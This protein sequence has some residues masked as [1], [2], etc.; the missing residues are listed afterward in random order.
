MKKVI[1]PVGL[2]LFTNF[3]KQN[4]SSELRTDFDDFKGDVNHFYAADEY[5]I[6]KDNVKALKDAVL[7]FALR[8][9]HASAEI[10]SIK[11][12]IK[13]IQKTYPHE[14]FTICLLA[15]DT[16]HSA[17]AVD[18][19][20]SP[21]VFDA[22][23]KGISGLS[24]TI[25]IVVVEKLQV[26][27]RED[28]IRYGMINLI[29]IIR[30]LS[31]KT[32]EKMALWKNIVLNITG[33]YKATIP[34]LTIL[35]QIYNIPLYY[36]FD[37][38]ESDRI[39][40]E[41]IR[42]PRAPIAI[43]W[44]IFERYSTLLQEIE[45]GVADFGTF[46]QQHTREVEEIYSC[47]EEIDDETE[48]KTFGFLSPLGMIL[49]EEFNAYYLV[50]VS[51]HIFYSSDLKK[52]RT[53]VEDAIKKLFHELGEHIK[54][55]IQNESDKQKMELKTTE[56]LYQYLEKLPSTSNLNHT[57]I[58][59]VKDLDN[60]RRKAFVFKYSPGKHEVRLCYDVE[61]QNSVITAITVFD[62]VAGN[63]SHNDYRKQFEDFYGKYIEGSEY[64]YLQ[65]LPK[66]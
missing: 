7:E 64:H 10:S 16:F 35:S 44:A 29:R 23:F 53:L 20:A 50:K 12:I 54:S 46:K 24:Q 49:W 42:I 56:D 21:K 51:P 25:E 36:I 33:G 45:N 62:C 13:D 58:I 2:S 28:F 6:H 26:N 47:V 17:F 4:S 3:F 37:S 41:L 18:I 27:K 38:S 43:D 61:L 34:Y 40:P 14:T 11:E 55:P 30:R 48:Q 22:H 32:A 60:Q 31:Q 19:L 65:I 9:K 52:K 63:F 57:G 66:S 5:E 8:D 39:I 1:T 15:S 59:K